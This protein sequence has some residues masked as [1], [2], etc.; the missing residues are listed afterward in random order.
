[1]VFTA[2]HSKVLTHA[3]ITAVVALAVMLGSK[4]KYFK[5]MKKYGEIIF[6]L[7]FWGRLHHADHKI[8]PLCLPE[9]NLFINHTPV[10]LGFCNRCKY[11]EIFYMRELESCKNTNT[12]SAK[13]AS[14]W[15][16]FSQS[17]FHFL[18]CTYKHSAMF[19]SN[20]DD[21]C[22]IRSNHS[23]TKLMKQIGWIFWC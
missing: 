1:M 11:R 9:F 17:V 15:F 4:R 23:G 7:T 21:R 14:D 20:S 19:E 22:Q 18:S 12:F 8:W 13:A 3:G 16:W 10:V 5:R 2:R 6:T